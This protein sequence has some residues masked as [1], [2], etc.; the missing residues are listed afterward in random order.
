MDP[1]FWVGI[2]IGAL[3]GTMLG[4]MVMAVLTMGKEPT[5]YERNC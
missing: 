2:G 3:L 5:D 4:A 1:L